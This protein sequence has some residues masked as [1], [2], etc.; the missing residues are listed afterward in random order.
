MTKQEEQN[1]ERVR[2]W[3]ETYNNDVERMVDECYAPNCEVISMM[4]G[5]TVNGR[6]ELRALERE[7]QKRQVNR[8]MHVYKTVAQGNTVAV[9]CEGAFG[10][11]RFKACVFLTFDDDGYIISDHTYSK[12][13]TGTTT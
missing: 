7:I 4:T 10:A 11:E 9:E 3:E 6:E 12:D 5:F 2:H 8:S 13:P 1:V